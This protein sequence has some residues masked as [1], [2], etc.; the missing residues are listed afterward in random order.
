MGL[1]NSG[2]VAMRNCRRHPFPVSRPPISHWLFPQFRN[3]TISFPLRVL[4]LASR[5]GKA[6]YKMQQKNQG[7]AYA[8]ARAGRPIADK[9]AYFRAWRNAVWG[10]DFDPIAVAV[11]EAV[12]TFSSSR[13]EADRQT[14]RD[15][16]VGASRNAT[17]CFA[18]IWDAVKHFVRAASDRVI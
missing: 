18:A 7:L 3:S 6:Q 8:H 4:C 1:W 14:D 16:R 11:D 17:S 13:S 15:T 5:G 9:G 12:S 2:N 10:G